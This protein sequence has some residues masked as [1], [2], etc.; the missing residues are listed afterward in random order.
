MSHR[1]DLLPLSLPPNFAKRTSSSAVGRV[2]STVFCHDSGIDRGGAAALQF[3]SFLLRPPTN[4]LFRDRGCGVLNKIQ[5]PKIRPGMHVTTNK[6][7]HLAFLEFGCVWLLQRTSFP[8]SAK[9]RNFPNFPIRY[10]WVNQS[11]LRFPVI[12]TCSEIKGPK[13]RGGFTISHSIAVE[14]VWIIRSDKSPSRMDEKRGWVGGDFFPP[15]PS[16]QCY[17]VVP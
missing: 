11:A 10:R 7:V 15:P 14:H 6:I 9:C 5:N 2:G 8:W 3:S 16:V 13:A 12:G 1:S 4:P 17:K